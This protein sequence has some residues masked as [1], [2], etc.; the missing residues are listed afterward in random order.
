MDAAF[1]ESVRAAMSSVRKPGPHDTVCKDECVFCFDTPFSRDGLY[2]NLSTLRGVGAD[3]LRVDRARTG[4]ALYLHQKFTKRKKP[5]PDGE[6]RGASEATE[7]TPTE[8]A[9]G[10]EG[11][12]AVDDAENAYETEETYALA[13]V[14]LRDASEQDARSGSA[15]GVVIQSTPYP[16]QELPFIVC[17]AVDAVIAHAGFHAATETTAWREELKES[18]Y[19]RELKQEPASA[20]NV[21][22]PDP[23]AWR[24]AESGADSNLWL[25][26]GDG[27][28]GSG[29]QRGGSGAAAMPPQAQTAPLT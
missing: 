7:T 10:V 11:G 14:S 1:L 27:H 29:R 28:I 17:D 21:I 2:V 6:E 9:I 20:N 23:T 12:F 22:S 3:H 19:A 5:K 26:L 16:N 4:N 13:F 24:C 25:N 8:M 15:A 18:K